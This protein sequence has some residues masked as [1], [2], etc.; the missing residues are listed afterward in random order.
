VFWEKTEGYLDG[1]PPDERDGLAPLRAVW[2]VEREQA[3]KR[4]IAYLDGERYRR[5]AEEFGGYLKEPGA[6]AVPLFDD[7]G[8]PLPSLVRHVVPVVVHG[9]VAAV[10]AYDEWVTQPDVPLER[11]HRLRIAAKGLRYALEFF[12]EVLGPE[13]GEAITL[14]KGLQDHL[15]D[16]NDALVASS[17]LRDFLVWGMWGHPSGQAPAPAVPAEPILAP[18]V[19]T[20]LASRQRELQHLLA[21]FPAAWG[22]FS[23]REFGTLVAA[24]LTPL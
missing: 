3:R 23:G 4:M 6:G 15:G 21:T 22:V 19:A 16:L 18:G 24:A 9:R 7:G 20:Y 12:R 13:A 11:L 10:R 2:E 14:V 5:F 1:L 8:E 17:L